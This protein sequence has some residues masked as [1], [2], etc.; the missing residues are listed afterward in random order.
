MAKDNRIGVLLILE[1]LPFP[2][3]RRAWQE[4]VALRDAG[5]RVHVIS[6]RGPIFPKNHEVIEDI[7]VYRY[8]VYEA[9]GPLGY[10]VEYFK[11][12]TSQFYLALKIFW[13]HRFRVV[14]TW[15]PPDI[16]FL[17]GLLFKFFGARYIYDHLDLNPELYLAKF[18]KKDFFYKLVCLVEKCAFRT[19]DV[20]LATNQSYRDIAI[21]RGGKSPDQVFIVRV[22]P[23]PDKM[24]RLDPVPKLKN[25]R[26]FLVV[27]LGVM[28]PQDGLDLLI[29]AID[30]I[31]HQGRDDIQFTLIGSGTEAP[32]LKSLVAEKKLEPWV[33]FTGR[34]PRDELAQYLSTA[35]V[36]VASDPLNPMNDK[37]TMGKVLEYM[38]FNLPVVQFEVTEGR[39]SAGEASLYARPND[40]LDFADK[41]LQLI[42]SEELRH[43]MGGIGR[44]R[45]EQIFN[46]E[47]DRQSLLEAY[48]KALSSSPAQPLAKIPLI[49]MY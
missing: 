14:H 32:R 37:S 24:K 13:R 5:Y 36:G 15:N 34:I 19:A 38:A 40:P 25:G 23:E 43:R 27:Y 11:A 20:S 29:Q 2:F 12:L 49:F 10:P 41:I 21:Q 16:M 46:W 45:I 1:N 18:G 22:S 26:K 8:R 48:A 7:D 35:D 28:G 3:V 4:A 33:N 31:I 30:H 9:S 39:R 17:N 6:P 44:Q 47:I 42:D